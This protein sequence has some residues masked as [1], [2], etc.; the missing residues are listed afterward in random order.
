[1]WCSLRPGSAAHL[2]TCLFY[3]P[4]FWELVE[5]VGP[6]GLPASTNSLAHC[7]FHVEQGRIRDGERGKLTQGTLGQGKSRN[8][9]V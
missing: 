5:L 1:M 3:S 2:E 4:G 9:Q 7:S 8:M 6:S